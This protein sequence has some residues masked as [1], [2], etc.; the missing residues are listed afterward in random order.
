MS[1]PTPTITFKVKSGDKE[2]L[3]SWTIYSTMDSP[4]DIEMFVNGDPIKIR[5]ELKKSDEK[6]PA[7]VMFDYKKDCLSIILINHFSA[8]GMGPHYMKRLG[9]VG[10]RE[11]FLHY[12]AFGVGKENAILLVS[13]YLDREKADI[14]PGE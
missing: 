2:L 13:M 9:T 12:R 6:T 1:E 11:L 5:F 8:L 3:G 14:T 10:N 4:V 7:S